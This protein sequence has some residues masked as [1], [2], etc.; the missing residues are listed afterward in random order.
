MAKKIRV[1]FIPGN[2]GGSPNDNW[3]PY[4]AAE[5]EEM[6]LEVIAREFPDNILARESYWIPFIRD[7]LKAD[8]NTILI[9]H[10]SGAIA[11]MRIAEQVKLLGSVLVG[12]YYTDLG[13]ENEKLGGYFDR[14]WHFETIKQNQHWI[15]IFGSTDDP[16]ISID[17]PRYL[18]KK[19]DCDYF[20][21]NDQGHFGG[22]YLKTTFPEIVDF[23]RSK[24][25]LL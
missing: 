15:G 25:R 11:A 5:F 4:L 7:E 24:L 6:G 3:F 22:D 10:S 20:E 18:H 12:T 19:L 1:I 23:V 17:E 2:G 9:G 16:W 13:I 14:P 8:E 21:Y